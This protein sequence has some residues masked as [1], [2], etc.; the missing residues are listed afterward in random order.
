MHKIFN[1]KKT[2]ITCVLFPLIV[3]LIGFLGNKAYTIHNNQIEIKKDIL[4]IQKS[5]YDYKI[6][7]D[8]QNMAQWESMNNIREYTKENNIKSEIS[9]L[10][11]K[12]LI[13]PYI[14]NKQNYSKNK[15]IISGIFSMLDF[16]KDSEFYSS[17]PKEDILNKV[18]EISEKKNFYSPKELKQQYINK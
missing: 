14:I 13:L 6:S 16:K 18:T 5:F 4:S 7:Q 17:S 1:Y 3:L 8:S 10:I 12:E 9:I 2:I 15:N 11:H